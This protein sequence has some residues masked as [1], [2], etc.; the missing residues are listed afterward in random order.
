MTPEKR[1]IAYLL[2]QGLEEDVWIATNCD[3]RCLLQ[4]GPLAPRADHSSGKIAYLYE[5]K[6]ITAGEVRHGLRSNR[7]CRERRRPAE[8]TPSR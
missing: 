4:S 2:L 7:T 8:W 6:H 3:C 1:Q 5:R